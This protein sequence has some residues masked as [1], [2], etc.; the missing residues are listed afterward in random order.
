MAEPIRLDELMAELERLGV[1]KGDDGLTCRELREY[2]KCSGDKA[3]EL[4]RK[5]LAAGMVIAGRAVR[6]A[7]DGIMR[8]T[9]VYRFVK[10]SKAKAK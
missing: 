8:P 2:W 9:P 6:P 4:L 7:I 10:K 1:P 3:H 5:L